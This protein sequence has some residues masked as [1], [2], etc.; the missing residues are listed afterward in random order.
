MLSINAAHEARSM[1]SLIR[2]CISHIR[3]LNGLTVRTVT[4]HLLILF[5]AYMRER[6]RASGIA[7][8]RRRG[9]LPEPLLLEAAE[10]V[11]RDPQ[12]LDHQLVQERTHA[13]PRHVGLGQLCE[14]RPTGAPED[15]RGAERDV[16]AYCR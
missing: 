7:P 15:I 2:S 11:R 12:M 16:S 5:S 10:R 9:S 14:L 3:H 6:R 4:F 13:D 8:R 1:F